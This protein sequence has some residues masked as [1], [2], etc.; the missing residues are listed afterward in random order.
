MSDK[1]R[2]A[3]ER[4]DWDVDSIP[5]LAVE[6]KIWQIKIYNGYRGHSG[7]L[8]DRKKY[9]DI[10]KKLQEQF[11]SIKWISPTSVFFYF[12]DEADAAYFVLW[13]N[14]DNFNID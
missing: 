13:A 7:H 11:G 2:I 10:R 12:T 6:K 14:S 3:F 8:T 5:T 9:E 1:E 4:K